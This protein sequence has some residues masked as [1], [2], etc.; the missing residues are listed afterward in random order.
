MAATGQSLL[1]ANNYFTVDPRPS[2][3]VPPETWDSR[4]YEFRAFIYKGSVWWLKSYYIC[5]NRERTVSCPGIRMLGHPLD[6]LS[7]R[8]VTQICASAKWQI[9]QSGIF[10]LAWEW[11]CQLH[12]CQGS[13]LDLLSNQDLDSDENRVAIPVATLPWK[14]EM[15][16]FRML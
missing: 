14:E 10:W 8:W 3:V 16:I 1:A 11:L 4:Y 2:R 7:S 5:Y 12:K 6:S 15:N 13:T 9:H